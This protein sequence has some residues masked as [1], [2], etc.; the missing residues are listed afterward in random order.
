MLMTV[1]TRGS[2]GGLELMGRPVPVF[3]GGRRAMV[4]LI[5][6]LLL[7]AGGAGIRIF[8]HEAQ[9]LPEDA[10]F[11]VDGT[12]VT[13]EQLQHRAALME[14][15]YGVVKPA[16]RA[17]VDDFNRSLAKAVAVSAIVERA[18]REQN[19]VIADKAASDQLQKMIA[20]SGTDRRAF[21]QGLGS[22]GLSERDVLD[23][24]KLQQA[25][26]RLFAQV[27]KEVPA[28]TD[29]D[30]KRYFAEHRGEMTVP[31]SRGLLNVVVS[32]ESQ[33]RRVAQL[34]KSGDDFATLAERFSI[35]ESTRGNGGS[36][37][38]VEAEQLDAGYATA[39]FAATNGQVFGPVKTS[40]G[41]NVGQVTA[42]HRATPLSF[43]QVKD[44]IASKLDQDAK[45]AAWDAFLANRIK[46]AHVQYAPDFRPSDPDAPPPTSAR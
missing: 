37:G 3:P 1:S 5:G 18:A 19:I 28:A 12:V 7:I 22:R 4:M 21:V 45:Q 39:A 29:A 2:G 20:D 8:R 13:K 9:G 33:A 30:I 41:W 31:E 35:D 42:I 14:F 10:V 15:L 24:I 46:A 27:T 17:K 23:E 11:R 36:L 40:H 34:A 26:V 38:T 32:S 44:S 43:P 16:E 25:N 6:L